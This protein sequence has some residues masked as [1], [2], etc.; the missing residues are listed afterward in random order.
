MDAT[1]LF[2]EDGS[3]ENCL[4]APKPLVPGGGDLRVLKLM[5]LFEVAGAQCSCHFFKK[6]EGDITELLNDVPDNLTLSGGNPTW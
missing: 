5:R 4:G 1:R 6:V 3:L 2:S